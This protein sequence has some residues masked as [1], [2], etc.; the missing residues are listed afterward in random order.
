MAHTKRSTSFLFFTYYNMFFQ[1]AY[2]FIQNFHVTLHR[3]FVAKIVYISQASII[4]K[5]AASQRRSHH[6]ITLL[7]LPVLF[8]LQHTTNRPKHIMHRLSHI[9]SS[10]RS[11]KNEPRITNP[12]Q[13]QMSIIIHNRVLHRINYCITSYK[14]RRRILTLC[15]QMPFRKLRQSKIVTKNDTNHLTVNFY[16]QTLQ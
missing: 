3:N 10:V 9:L 5:S 14:Y 2:C 7:P 12:I 11:N 4:K 13:L 1:R 6:T 8:P 16:L 15:K